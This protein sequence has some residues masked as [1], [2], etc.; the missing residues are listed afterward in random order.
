LALRSV[1]SNSSKMGH[2]DPLSWVPLPVVY[3]WT[4]CFCMEYIRPFP[5]KYP[6]WYI[7]SLGASLIALGVILTFTI[8]FFLYRKAGPKIWRSSWMFIFYGYLAMQ[9]AGALG[10]MYF[11]SRPGKNYFGRVLFGI[12]IWCGYWI[13][14]QYLVMSPMIDMGCFQ[15]KGLTKIAN[16]AFSLVMAV[17]IFYFEIHDED[18]EHDKTYQNI[19]KAT[20]LVVYLGNI[21]VFVQIVK[22]RWVCSIPA[23]LILISTFLNAFSLYIRF[24]DKVMPNKNEMNCIWYLLE[25]VS[26]V[27]IWFYFVLT[28]KKLSDDDEF[29][30][31]EHFTS[32]QYAT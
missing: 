22:E 17:V 16:Y 29:G 31:S 23:L 2:S 3:P 14:G 12:D 30:Y 32:I 26:L 10:F 19:I 24:N 5:D 15:W 1:L 9:L 21:M 28:R 27:L 13:V 25:G 4:N 18:P 11:F 8:L 6:G 7:I 20:Q